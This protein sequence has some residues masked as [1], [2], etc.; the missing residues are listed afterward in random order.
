MER[1]CLLFNAR[2]PNVQGS[3]RI[4]IAADLTPC[5]LHTVFVEPHSYAIHVDD[6]LTAT[7]EYVDP[8]N[9]HVDQRT[10]PTDAL[11]GFPSLP[12]R[13]PNRK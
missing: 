8:L 7:R 12:K 5:D 4:C 1:Q 2:I 13:L 6:R 3:I 11:V 9:S 10:T